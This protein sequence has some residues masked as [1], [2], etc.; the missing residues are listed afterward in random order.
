MGRTDTLAATSDGK[1]VVAQTA[2]SPAGPE[3]AIGHHITFTAARKIHRVIIVTR[4]AAARHHADVT[5][6]RVEFPHTPPW[7]YGH[8]GLVD[9]P[10]A[11]TIAA[12]ALGPRLL[13]HNNVSQR[14]RLCPV[15]THPLGHGGRCNQTKQD[16]ADVLLIEAIGLCGCCTT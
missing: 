6:A 4:N 13:R 12:I 3:P 15:I 9:L 8:T 2:H 14:G 1:T 11:G 16:L 10:I 7:Q 5:L